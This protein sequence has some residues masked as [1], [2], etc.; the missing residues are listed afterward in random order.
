MCVNSHS[1]QCPSFNSQQVQIQTLISDI[2]YIIMPIK[3][4]KIAVVKKKIQGLLN[5]VN[6]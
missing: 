5:S 2:Y 4:K 3:K 1:N 6:E